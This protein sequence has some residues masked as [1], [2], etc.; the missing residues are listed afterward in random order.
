MSACAEHDE[1]WKGRRSRAGNI[2]QAA[3][4]A[5]TNLRNKYGRPVVERQHPFVSSSSGV[6]Q[7][8]LQCSSDVKLL[9]RKGRPRWM[10]ATHSPLM[11]R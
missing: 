7:A 1:G 11:P 5:K 8:S 3:V 4:I 9:P 2:V 6:L 10:L